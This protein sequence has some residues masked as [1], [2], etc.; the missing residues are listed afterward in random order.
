MEQGLALSSTNTQV[1][2]WTAAAIVAIALHAAVIATGAYW[3]IDPDLAAGARTADIAPYAISV[4][5]DTYKT[6]PGPALEEATAAARPPDASSAALDLPRLEPSPAPD[7]SVVLPEI[8]R[9]QPKTEDPK[10]H[11]QPVAQPSD[12]STGAPVTTAPMRIPDAAPARR[13]AAPV[14]GVAENAAFVQA[15]WEKKLIAHIAA[16]KRYPSEARAQGQQGV[17]D[18]LATIDVDGHVLEAQILKGS[19]SAILDQAALDVLRRSS[20]LPRPPL[21]VTDGTPIEITVP[22]QFRIR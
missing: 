7:P 1:K 19:G 16:H 8:S 15:T 14:P 17:V 13:T 11:A 3:I 9:S 2:R 10:S 21:S 12:A 6:P 4:D 18:L 22:V 20:P 5:W